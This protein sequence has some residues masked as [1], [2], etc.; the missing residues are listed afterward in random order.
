VFSGKRRLPV[1]PPCDFLP[2][3]ELPALPDPGAE[4]TAGVRAPDATAPLR[5]LAAGAR[6]VVITIPD[7]SR[8]CPNDLILPALL[9]ELNSGGV[10]DDGITVLVGCGLHRTTSP[11]EKTALAG[12][13]ASA[14]VRVE[15]AQGQQS[16][17]TGLG[18][19]SLGCPVRLHPGVAAADLV[20]SVGVLEPHQYAGYSAGV[21]G[22]AIGCAAEE[23]IVWTHSPALISRNGV[24]LCSLEGNPFQ[25]TLREVAAAT[26]LRF[27]VTAVM[28]DAGGLAAVAAGDPVA[29]QRRLAGSFAPAW[30]NETA[31]PY[32]V[33][34]AGVK[35]PKDDSLYQASRAATYIALAAH[36]ALVDGGLLLLC[37]DLPLGP[38]DGPGELN[39]GRLLSSGEGAA[40]VIA[41]GL[42]GPL[43]PGGQRAFVLARVLQ[44]FRV[45]VCG[46]A[47]GGFLGTLG[48]GSYRSVVEGLAD[49]RAA[50]RGHAP[51]ILAVAD[52]LTSIVRAAPR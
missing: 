28:D 21:K 41:R 19:T 23:T 24:E 3:P 48:I 17:M 29:V 25:E 11:E 26:R 43:G 47:D 18:T 34:V 1:G 30:L 33:I 16:P 45:G 10:P 9:D 7:L 2:P 20:I 39:F 14:R 38:G 13:E 51:R 31:D 52:A 12:G 6:R 32:D 27:A 5:D 42:Q 22:V 35:A 8:A 4:L 50:R 36:P 46:S 44:R 37:A 40:G 49:A 15:D